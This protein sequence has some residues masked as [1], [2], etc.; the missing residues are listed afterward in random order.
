M[1]FGICEVCGER[2]RIK[3]KNKCVRCYHANKNKLSREGKIQNHKCLN[4][5]KPVKILMCPK[6]KEII[7]Y[8]RRCEECL[9]K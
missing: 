1:K 6:C 7:K 4:C 2:G 5:G 8:H 3:C 9:K